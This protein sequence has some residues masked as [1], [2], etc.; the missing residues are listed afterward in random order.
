M[1]P[2]LF[3]ATNGL[4]LWYSDD[5]GDSLI[6]MGSRA[7]M[8][9]GVQIWALASDPAD[10]NLLLVGT[11]YGL[12]RLD[13]KKKE[14]FHLPSPMDE[15]FKITALAFSPQNPDTI[16]AGTQYAAL[17]RSQD[18]GRSW[19]KLDVEV[20]EICSNQAQSRFTQIAFD[21][22]DARLGFAGVELDGIWRTTDGG[23]TW[24]KSMAGMTSEDIHG[25]AVATNG[26]C[27]D[28]W[29]SSYQPGRWRELAI[30]AARLAVDIHPRDR[31][32]RR[33]QWRHV[34]HQWRWSAWFMGPALSQQ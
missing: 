27:R 21:P 2:Q 7:G 15:R 8:Y 14:I 19:L 33:R 11:N 24:C 18:H 25:V 22:T 31:A 1:T 28:R 16:F 17:Y 10:P 32:W 20:P 12:F 4:G 30:A 29:R 9:S 3:I 5:C 26:S 34:P 13:R 6:R 23:T